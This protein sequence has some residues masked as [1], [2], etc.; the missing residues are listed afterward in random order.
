[1][2]VLWVCPV[3]GATIRH[4]LLSAYHRGPAARPPIHDHDGPVE[5]IPGNRPR[6]LDLMCGA[7][8]ASVGY[9]LA[10]F[11]VVGVDIV[12]QPNYPFE[13]HRADA[14]TF[15]LDGFDV[16]HASPP[17]QFRTAYRRRR[18][19]V[20]PAPNLIPAIRERLLEA[21]VPYVI[22]NVEGARDELREP[23]MLCGS[24]FGLDVRRHRL[25]EC[26]VPLKAPSCNH[27]AQTPRFAPATNRT[28][29]RS[30][31]EIGVWRI[32]LEVQRRAMGISWMTLAELSQA[33]PP[34]YNGMDR[35]SGIPDRRRDMQ[36][37]PRTKGA[38]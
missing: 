12:E 26:S 29:L 5:M 20:R 10:G 33:I 30:T 24:M 8:G 15:P 9:A 31:V 27:P 14:L 7:G 25:F 34:A 28:N 22:E 1:M 2:T 19:H 32:P 17:C 35:T 16:I 23:I 4:D 21:G 3:C 37:Q 6:I 36:D 13:F 18:A 38:A 11:E